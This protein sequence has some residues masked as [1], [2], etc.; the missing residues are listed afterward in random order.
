MHADPN[1]YLL[2]PRPYPAQLSLVIPMYNEESVVPF[3]RSALT[4]FM[5]ETISNAR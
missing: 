5:A 1:S 4:Q 2:C 3:L